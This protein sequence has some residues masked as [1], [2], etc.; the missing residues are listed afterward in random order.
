MNILKLI[1]IALLG[2]VTKAHDAVKF[3]NPTTA[4]YSPTSFDAFAHQKEERYLQDQRHRIE[5]NDGVLKV[6]FSQTYL[7]GSLKKLNDEQVKNYEQLMTKIAQNLIQANDSVECTWISQGKTRRRIINKER[8]KKM[9][10]RAKKRYRARNKINRELESSSTDLKGCS[11]K[12]TRRMSVKFYFVLN[13]LSDEATLMKTF[14]KYYNYMRSSEG[15]QAVASKMRDMEVCAISATPLKTIPTSIFTNDVPTRSIYPMPHPTLTGYPSNSQVPSQS[16]S[17]LQIKFRGISEA[18]S[19]KK[20]KI[21]VFWNPPIIHSNTESVHYHLFVAH[22]RFDFTSK[23]S[24]STISEFKEEFKNSANNQYI[25]LSELS[26]HH[27]SISC[28]HLGDVHT[29]LLIAESNGQYSL[30]TVGDEVVVSHVDPH[31]RDDVEIFGLF[32]P[33]EDMSIELEKATTDVLH[34]LTFSSSSGNSLSKE[35]TD[36]KSS[37]YIYGMTIESTTFV[38]K[39]EEVK[40]QSEEEVILMVVHAPLR[41]IFDELN[42]DGSFSLSNKKK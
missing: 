24:L 19:I 32:V 26:H 41:E 35:V 13:T 18:Y 22:G 14:D 25:P 39:I 7:G 23:L 8:R 21:D 11:D 29:L 4:I 27:Y 6:A 28:P 38:R 36:L 1:T 9:K 42:I 37:D 2:D 34:E 16:P 15:R 10:K 3:R 33:S 40:V 12:K 17:G 31:R 20:G 30:N 5:V